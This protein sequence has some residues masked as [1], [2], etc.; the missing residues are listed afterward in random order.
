MASTVLL[1]AILIGAALSALAEPFRDRIRG[2]IRRS[3]VP[4]D[5]SQAAKATCGFRR[6]ETIVDHDSDRIDCWPGPYIPDIASQCRAKGCIWKPSTR[7]DGS[8]TGAPWCFYPAERVAF[9]VAPGGCSVVNNTVQY[10]LVRPGNAHTFYSTPW[11]AVTLAV[12]ELDER[13]LRIKLY[14]PEASRYEVPVSLNKP[15]TGSTNPLYE[16]R[17]FNDPFFYFKVIRKSTAAVLFDTSL[18]GG[19]VLEDQYLQVKTRLP[20]TKIYGFGETRHA[21]FRLPTDVSTPMWAKD[22]PP[23]YENGNFYGFHPYYMVVEDD[24]KAHGVLLLTSN[25]METRRSNIPSLTMKTIGGILDLYFLLG[26]SA[27]DVTTLYT[28][29]VGRPFLPPYWSLGFQL[30]RWGY[31]NL[32]NLKRII[33]RNRAAGVPQDVQTLDIDYM[34]NRQDFTVD[35]EAFAGLEEYVKELKREGIRVV[36]IL[37]P[38]IHADSATKH[39]HDPPYLSY[40]RGLEQDVYI[41]WKAEDLSKTDPINIG[42]NNI[43]LGKVW[44][45]GRACFPDFFTARTRRWW[46]EEVKR[47][48]ETLKF[49]GLWIDM[50]EPASFGTNSDG[51]GQWFCT[52]GDL[53]GNHSCIGLKCPQNNLENPPYQAYIPNK[54]S[55]KTICMSMEQECRPGQMCKHYDVHNLYGWSQS[56]PTYEANLQATGSRPFV[57]SRSTYPG[58]GKYVGHWLGDNGADWGALR[59]SIVGMLEFNLFGIPYIGADICGFFM[60]PTEELCARWMQL[61]AFYPYSRNHNGNHFPDQ[62]PAQ[63][64]LVADVS[65]KALAI[66]YRLLPYLYTLFYEAHVYGQTVIR[67]LHHEFKHEEAAYDIQTQ[68]LWGEGLMIAPVVYEGQRQREVYFPDAVWY[69]LYGQKVAKPAGPATLM[70]PMPIDHIGVYYQ[71]GVVFPAQAP[72]LNTVQTRNNPFQFIVALNSRQKAEGYVYWD[73]GDSINPIQNG[74]YIDGYISCNVTNPLFGAPFV[75]VNYISE[76]GP[77]PFDGDDIRVNQIFIYGLDIPVNRVRGGYGLEGPARVSQ[78]GGVTTV[79]FSAPLSAASFGLFLD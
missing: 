29:L 61:G 26:E 21:T 8:S 17:V 11:S 52:S 50:N 79:T 47:Q 4:Q 23:S 77:V 33:N 76:T 38:A 72:G 7:P 63:W 3:L 56:E 37:D 66:R 19:I 22:E 39:P 36:I 73:D 13:K 65:K 12:E 58:A 44:P 75:H 35:Y 74:K 69:D 71:G 14:N 9:Q 18:Y 31:D 5:L 15:T 54:L 67:P 55:D 10:R 68:F 53:P 30:S 24:T 34:R 42:P 57:I 25:G 64:P 16:V 51:T 2:N 45:D 46:I 70:V 48:Y 20:T 1:F 78:I 6:P 27:E 49:D 60:V 28:E 62:D 59:Y 40:N 32:S 43:L 41:K